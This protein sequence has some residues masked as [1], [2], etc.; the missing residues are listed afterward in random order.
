[1][2][3]DKNG[4]PGD[5]APDLRVIR[6]EGETQER[7][8]VA[9]IDAMCTEH[10]IEPKVR[11]ELITSGASISDARK[12]V[13]TILQERIKN[14]TPQSAPVELNEKERKRYSLARAIVGQINRDGKDQFTIDGVRVDAGFELEIEQ[15]LEKKLPLS[16]KRRGGILFPTFTSRQAMEDRMTMSV[17]AAQRAVQALMLRAGLDSK[18]STKG[19]ELV[20]TQPGEFIDLLRNLMVLR[21]AG[22]RT[23]AGLTGPVSF[24]KQTGAASSAWVGE[25]PGADVADSNLLLGL[26][27][28]SPKTLMSSTSY[29]RQ[30][31]VSALSASVDADTMVREDLALI[32]A[33]AID[34]A[35]F[36]GTGASNDPRGLMNIAGV[37]LVSIGTNGGAPSFGNICDLETAV[38][39]ANVPTDSCGYITNAVMRGK[40]KQTL[41]FP[42]AN[43]GT[44]VW[45]G[46]NEMNGY[47]ALVTK[48]APRNLTKGTN[49][50]CH[51]IFFGAWDQAIFGEWGILELIPDPLRLK[52]QGMIE[53]TAFQM[54]DFCVRYPEAFAVIKDAR[55]V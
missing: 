7:T 3:D 22:V 53:V 19:A 14:P 12:R 6:A 43:T 29:S 30:L 11:G 37:G 35:G 44:P 33:L 15:E 9:E 55:N 34:L 25:N 39:D 42:T 10:A 13:L 51:S 48:Q 1:M 4:A 21:Q 54:V 41:T 40:L 17:S 27:T 31:L 16:Y 20:F 26:V 36:T 32:M 50:D 28:L 23:L 8:R 38:A 18:T 49:S 45:Q 47:N 24:P 5:G 46:K 2:K 52:K